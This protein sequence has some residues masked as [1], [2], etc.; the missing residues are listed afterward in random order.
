M[1]P[2]QT[3]CVIP[4]SSTH[5]RLVYRNVYCIDI[6]IQLDGFLSIRDGAYNLFDKTKIFEDLTPIQGLKRFLNR[7]VDKNAASHR[8]FSPNEEDNQLSP[9]AP[10]SMMET[11]M[12]SPYMYQQ[13]IL[14][15]GLILKSC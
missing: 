1:L 14:K 7:F 11:P 9:V 3:F 4:Q 8:R 6:V 15:N 2:I 5:L 12:E 10:N 13:Q